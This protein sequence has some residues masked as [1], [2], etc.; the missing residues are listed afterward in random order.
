[1]KHHAAEFTFGVK[2]GSTLTGRV[3]P[4]ISSSGFLMSDSLLLQ[5]PSHRRFIGV[6]AAIVAGSTPGCITS[7]ACALASNGSHSS[8][9]CS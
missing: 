2:A 7:G 6:A 1:M 8:T 4:L 3:L 5:V 9:K